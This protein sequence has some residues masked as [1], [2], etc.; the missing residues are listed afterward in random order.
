VIDDGSGLSRQYNAGGQPYGTTAWSLGGGNG[1]YT[2]PYTFTANGNAFIE[3][4]V[5]R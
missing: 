4:K 1:V 2:T 5:I 3:L